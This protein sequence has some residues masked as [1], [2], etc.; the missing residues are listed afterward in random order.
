MGLLDHMVALFLGFLRNLHNVFHHSCTN[1]HSY[2]QCRRVPF[3][4]HPLQ[5]L[6]F[7]D[8]LMIAFLTIVRWYLIV[9]LIWISL[10]I[11]DI[12]HLFLFLLTI[13]ISLEKCLFRSCAHVLIRLLIIYY[14][15]VVK[16]VYEFNFFLYKVLLK[17]LY[18]DELSLQIF[19]A[20]LIKTT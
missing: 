3:S 17:F 7:V 2:Q 15:T 19:R 1:F 11:S 13:C 9:I 5:H 16:Y 20:Q 10:I 8:F 4:P 18:W 14:N 12:E 6:F